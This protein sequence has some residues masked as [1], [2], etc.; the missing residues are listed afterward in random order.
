MQKSA[1]ARH[2]LGKI[3]GERSKIESSF[4]CFAG[5]YEKFF[6]GQCGCKLEGLSVEAIASI[7]AYPW[8]GNL[9]ELRNS[10]ERAVIMAR[11]DKIAPVD[12]P[13]EMSAS[14]GSAGGGGSHL[15][16][17]GSLISLEKLEEMHLRKV[18]ERT[19]SLTE[20]AQILGIDQATLYRK[21]K[22]IGLE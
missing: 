15:A 16:Q 7:R 21:R 5:H 18:L 10:I 13:S 12:F 22:K 19:P 4:I 14:N 20:A 2:Q 3:S 8:P 6:A 9:R 11:Q 17:V 1:A